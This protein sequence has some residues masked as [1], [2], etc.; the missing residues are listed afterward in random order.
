MIPEAPE[1]KYRHLFSGRDFDLFDEKGDYDAQRKRLGEVRQAAVK[2][3]LEAGSL[4]DVLK[5][6]PEV[7]VPYEVGQAL[8]A[9]TSDEMEN[10]IL[11]SLLNE[12]ADSSTG[13]LVAGFVWARYLNNKW[14]WVDDILKRDWEIEKKVAFLILLPF[15]DKVWQRVS[16]HL[17]EKDEGLYWQNAWV[18]PYGPDR[19][20]TVAIEKLL[21]FGR[22]SHALLCVA[23]TTDNE[24]RFSE[25]LATRALLAVLESP[26]SNAQLDQYRT[27]EVIK[28]LQKSDSA[29]QAALFKIEWNFLQWIVRFP[30]GSLVTLEKKLAS[31]PSF[32]AEVVGLV[33][34]SNDDEENEYEE[35][36]EQKKSRARN[37]Y[38][39]LTEWRTVPGKN[40]GGSLDVDAFNSWI[41]KARKIT[42]LSG[43]AE[44]AQI[45]IGHV[46]TCAPAD[47][48]GLWVHEAVA[49]VL[50]L[51]DTD[52][53]RS[54]FTTQLFND[55]GVYG[56]TAGGEERGL[57]QESR[58]RADAL[59]AKGY[60][61]FA[62][63]MR[64][65]A[66][67]YERQAK[68]ESKRD[69]FDDLIN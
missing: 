4:S 58:E 53:M 3:I 11:P 18:D 35:S 64:E 12:T 46:L 57:A 62:T 51:R 60:S 17:G 16:A 59:D 10:K 38:K 15:E 9:I 52:E 54:G 65:F 22:P 21:Q 20:L 29:D 7:T 13:Q 67:G 5:L 27:V 31:D 56:F 36:D 24:N 37:G 49:K 8:G 2:A 41:E 14:S 66:G 26:E 39:L 1:L 6:A 34:R 48:D 55:R 32:F 43:H 45:Q 69:P 61:R 42:E 30:T 33:F 23:R 47:P 63:A 40:D 44:V 68:H 19:D 28:H 25:A 50:N